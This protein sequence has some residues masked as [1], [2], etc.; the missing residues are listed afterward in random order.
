MTRAILII[1]F[2]LFFLN[3]NICSYF[4]DVDT[5]TEEWW[6]LRFKIYPFMWTLP[7]LAVFLNVEKWNRIFVVPVLVVMVQDIVDR[8]FFDYTNRDWMDWATGAITV[9]IMAYIYFKDV[10]LRR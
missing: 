8:I 3:Y 4:Y 7:T 2:L 5:Q 1:V 9:L 10:K 6:Q